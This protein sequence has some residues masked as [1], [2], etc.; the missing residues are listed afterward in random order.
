MKNER[1][2]SLLLV[3]LLLLVQCLEDCW[4]DNEAFVAVGRAL[5]FS[6][7]ATH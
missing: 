7:L 6:L 4:H 2:T 3:E 5:A 1:E